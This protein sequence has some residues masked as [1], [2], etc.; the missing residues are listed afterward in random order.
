ME[1]K[2]VLPETGECLMIEVGEDDTV[3]ELRQNVLQSFGLV[4]ENKNG[5]H[6]VVKLREDDG[7]RDLG[8]D[9]VLVRD[10]ALENSDE[11][12]VVFEKA[13]QMEIKVCK[14]SS[15]T[16]L[17]PANRHSRYG[18]MLKS[19]CVSPCARWVVTGSLYGNLDVYDA[20]KG[21]HCGHR[22]L[23]A[24][25][26]DIVMYRHGRCIVTL[27]EFYVEVLDI[28]SLDTVFYVEGTQFTSIAL[29]HGT[30]ERLYVGEGNDIHVYEAGTWK[31][32]RTVVSERYP[33]AMTVAAAGG[34]IL[35]Y[36][37]NGFCVFDTT[38]F[39]VISGQNVKGNMCTVSTCGQYV[40]HANMLSG[41]VSLLD[42][43][44]MEIQY[45][46]T[47]K[48]ANVPRQYYGL[49]G[50]AV[51]PLIDVVYCAK[52]EGVEIHDVS[53][54]VVTMVSGA[55]LGHN[56]VSVVAAVGDYVF[57]G[58]TSHVTVFHRRELRAGNP[59]IRP[60]RVAEVKDDSCCVVC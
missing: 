53:R 55:N 27:T 26:M 2:A 3:R 44:S 42:V 38:D 9:N 39:D 21:I 49:G 45:N 12:V 46:G 34:K 25:L 31:E 50:I 14:L 5:M 10:L 29:S 7:L 57:V 35:Q 16:I 19:I 23:A 47:C 58:S 48:I 60:R 22:S 33:C 11:V 41:D 24:P 30:D 8:A 32:L 17:E 1:V 4:A 15:G 59:T 36:D 6:S 20:L 37:L 43:E 51:S 13:A 40:A 56:F 52:E 18:D 28:R 54:R